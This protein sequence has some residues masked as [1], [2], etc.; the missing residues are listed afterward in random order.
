MSVAKDRWEKREAF[1]ALI[2]KG[3]FQGY[4][5]NDDIIIVFPEAEDSEVRLERLQTFFRSAGVDVFEDP[6][7]IPPHIAQDEEIDEIHPFDLSAI[8]SDDT[9]GLYLKEM[10]RVPLLTTEQEVDLATRIERGNFSEAD[11]AKT[12]GRLSAKRRAELNGFVQDARAARDHLIKANT[13]LVVSIAKKY[14]GRGV[15]FLDPSISSRKEI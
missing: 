1:A 14:M 4:I 3:E 13:R 7:Q 10:A 6:S 15:P 11:L 8:S 5:T 9:V 2:E 12:N